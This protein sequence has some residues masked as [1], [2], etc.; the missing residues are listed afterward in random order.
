MKMSGNTIFMT[1]GTSGIGLGLALRFAALGNKVIISGRRTELLEQ[2]TAEHEGIE[3]VVLDVQNPDSIRSAYQ[4]VTE[5]HPELNV[6]VN[7]AGIMLPENLRNPGHLAVAEATVATNLLGPIR[8]LT[9]FVPF[10][11]GQRDPVILNVTSGV[12][13]VALPATPTYGATK[14][15]LHAYT[16]ALRVQLADT[17]VQ[18]IEL[19]PPATRTTLMNQQN[20]ERSM[21]LD[22]FLSEATRL[23]QDEPEAKE[24]LV[25]RVKRLRFAERD[26]TYDQILAG[27]S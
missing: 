11:L 2:I 6:L 20:L 21:P 19:V 13:F 1:G 5:T 16:E 12:G 18:V 10:L 17:P 15:A 8:V 25:E 23:L 26:G 22:D 27:W 7:L 3:G 24:I 4:Q 14:L 9:H